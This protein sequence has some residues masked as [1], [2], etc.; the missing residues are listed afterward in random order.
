MSEEDQCQSRPVLA[1]ARVKLAWT[2]DAGYFHNLKLSLF[3]EVRSSGKFAASSKGLG[4]A[5]KVV[6]IGSSSWLTPSKLIVNIN[7]LLDPRPPV[8]M[9]VVYND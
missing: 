7:Q 6:H 3:G 5:T 9:R 8:D 2:H 4:V 1:R